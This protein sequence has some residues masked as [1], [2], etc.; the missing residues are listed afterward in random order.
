M[1]TSILFKFHT[2]ECDISRTI[3]GIEVNDGSFFGIYDTFS[4]ELK[5]FFRPEFPINNC[6]S[7]MSYD[8][9]LLTNVN[10]DLKRERKPT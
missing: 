4:F 3:W 8:K 2:L 5:L 1:A 10:T 7:K 9:D 6:K